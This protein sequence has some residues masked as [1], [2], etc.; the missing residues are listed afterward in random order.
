MHRS[1]DEKEREREREREKSVSS[2]AAND[3]LGKKNSRGLANEHPRREKEKE[4]GPTGRINEASAPDF[5]CFCF[6]MCM[7]TPCLCG[8]AREREREREREVKGEKKDRQRDWT[9]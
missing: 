2:V 1:K 5:S 3:L 6:C 7:Y 8:Q 4:Q 9:S